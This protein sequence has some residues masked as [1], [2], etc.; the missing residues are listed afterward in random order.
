[1]NFNERY[2]L[3]KTY[4]CQQ[5]L[6]LPVRFLPQKKTFSTIWQKPAKHVII[7]I[8]TDNILLQYFCLWCF[9]MEATK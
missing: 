9:Y 6:F 4:F 7:V 5:I 8:N 3:A 1:M 2:I